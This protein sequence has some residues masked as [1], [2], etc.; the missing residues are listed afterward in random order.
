M[1]EAILEWIS[2]VAAIPGVIWLQQIYLGLVN[3]SVLVL[4]A[5]GL[6][7]ILGLLGIINLA[8]GAF[9]MFGAYVGWVLLRLTGNFWVALAL[10]PF[11]GAGMGAVVERFLLTPTY[12][13]KEADFLGIL[14]TFGLSLA[15]P[16]L[17][18]WIFGNLGLPYVKPLSTPLFNLGGIP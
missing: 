13:K 3:G 8:H 4:M 17:A 10:S 18:R 16:D 5:L 12:G 14:V 11:L 1:L 2:E 15:S 6:T 9:Y 7:I